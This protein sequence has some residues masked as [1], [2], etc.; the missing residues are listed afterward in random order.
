L[1]DE[2]L[3]AAVQLYSSTVDLRTSFAHQRY[4]PGAVKVGCFALQARPQLAN[5]RRVSGVYC[6]D[7]DGF[8]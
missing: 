8:D 3:P 5:V 4:V 1:G 2:A 6:I 7:E